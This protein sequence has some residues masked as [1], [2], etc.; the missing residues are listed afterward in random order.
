MLNIWNKNKTSYNIN[1]EHIIKLSTFGTFQQPY[2]M[3]LV[4]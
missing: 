4:I 2:R 1:I 3:T